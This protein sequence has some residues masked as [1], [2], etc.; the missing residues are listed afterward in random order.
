MDYPLT[1]DEFRSIYAKVPRLCV[2]LVILKEGKVLLTK[3]KIDP[4]KGLWHLPGGT[5]YFGETIKQAISRVALNELGLT[6]EMG[7]LFGYLE[8]PDEVKNDWH[9]WPI[10]LEIEV[11]VLDGEVGTNDQADGYDYFSTIPENTVKSHIG[12]LAQTLGLEQKV[13]KK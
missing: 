7:K 12:F 4:Y 3:R 1:Q 8:F 11:K 10:S 13:V 9:G 5:V 2:D 6:V